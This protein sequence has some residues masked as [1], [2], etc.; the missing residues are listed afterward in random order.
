MKVPAIAPRELAVFCTGS[1]TLAFTAWGLSG[2][3]LWSLHAL[4][5]GGM[6]TFLL[7]TIPLP[8]PWNGTDGQHGNMQNLKRLFRFPV[9]WLSLAFLLYLLIQGLNPNWIQMQDE[10]GW[11]LEELESIRWLPSSVSANYKTMNAFRV[12]ASFGA[13]YLLVCGL[14]VGLQ[15]R[16]SV[17]L[18]LWI[19]LLSGVGS[20]WPVI[21][22]RSLLN[23]L[24]KTLDGT[25]MVIFY[26][27]SFDGT[28]LHLFDRKDTAE[29]ATGRV[30]A[31]RY[32][33]AFSLV[34]E[35]V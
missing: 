5:V 26:P 15:R 21:R 24:H 17:V 35:E 25:P 6:L 2:V 7:A 3:R 12:L 31:Q 18:S 29:S 34:P 13:A 8:G 11:W 1:L 19:F 9:F 4:L 28:T 10:R 14:W 27:G 30:G 20:V 22:L 23:C 16:V 32:Y 33:R